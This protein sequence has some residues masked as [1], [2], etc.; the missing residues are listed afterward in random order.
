MLADKNPTCDVRTYVGG[1]QVC[2]H[3]WTLLDSDQPQPWPDQ[4]LVYY[5]KYRFYFQ[6][7][8]PKRHVIVNPRAVWAIGAFI[9]E[10][11]VPQCKAGTA[12]KDC[13][14]TIW[15]V[16]KLPASK[17]PAP[18]LHIAAAH[19]HCHAPTCLAM[20]IWNNVTGELI[21]RQKP[22]YGG[23]GMIAD[24]KFDEPGYI[25][26]PPCLWGSA[27]QGLEPMPLASGETFTIKAITNS[28]S[29]H[30]GE[31]A[32]PEIALVPWNTS[33]NTAMAGYAS[34]DTVKMQWELLSFNGRRNTNK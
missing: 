10:Y 23:T 15:G 13:T 7:Y 17:Q 12:T 9:G 34:K 30:H 16:V 2:K 6:P 31:M 25:A 26:Q 22:V 29:G 4:P 5:Q 20:E 14:H 28:T 32:F 8:A 21:C 27:D 19:F 33:A 18:P 24:H 11:D 1:L 3:M